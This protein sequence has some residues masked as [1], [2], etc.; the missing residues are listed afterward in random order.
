MPH[1]PA[2]RLVQATVATSSA[3][4]SVRPPALPPRPLESTA[5]GGVFLCVRAGGLPQAIKKPSGLDPQRR[6][7][8][9]LRSPFQRPQ[10]WHPTF[11]G[12]GRGS[13]G[14]FGFS[15]LWLLPTP[16][17]GLAH[18]ARQQYRRLDRVASK[19][20]AR[21][22]GLGHSFGTPSAGPSRS[23]STL[24]SR[25]KR[26]LSSIWSTDC[27]VYWEEPSCSCCVLRAAVAEPC[28]RRLRTCYLV[29][30]GASGRT[31]AR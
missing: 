30:V 25:P 13:V 4:A 16:S 5:P 29:A 11:V 15:R 3:G 2:R 21:F 28:R 31:R 6:R 8:T 9:T 24:D 10:H 14:P 18:Q 23:P 26:H 27:V 12:S 22:D 20:A 17:R 7:V 1:G 19:P